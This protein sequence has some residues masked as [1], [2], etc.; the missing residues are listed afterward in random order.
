MATN[1]GLVYDV[2]MHKGED[3]DFYL[4][5]GFDVVAF[6]ADPKLIALCKARFRKEIADRRLVIVEGAIA[7]AE[8]GETVTFYR[9]SLSV[10]G[11]TSPEWAARNR[12]AGETNAAV[13]IRR[14]DMDEA[15]SRYGVPHYLKVDVEGVDTLILEALSR[16]LDRPDFISIESEMRSFDGLV[17]EFDLL[18]RLGYTSFNLLQQETIPN[19]VMRTMDRDGK[20]F[21]YR[22]A[23][24]ASGPFGDDLPQRWRSRSQAL[25]DYKRVFAMYRLF[26]NDALVRRI[27]GARAVRVLSRLL[28]RPL[29]G[30]YDTH[31]RLKA[32]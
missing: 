19:S 31:A 11:T 8:A 23:D 22:F 10:W 32:G 30:W 14:I 21:A 20:P 16:Q 18:E 5:K 6:E 24:H 15:F 13:A 3:T 1:Q 12:R 25:Q 4:R 27:F 17:R 2:G 26:G 7:S 28:R 9:S 29:P